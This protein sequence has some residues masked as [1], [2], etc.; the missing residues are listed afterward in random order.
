MPRISWTSSAVISSSSRRKNASAI[1]TGS[2][3][4]HRPKTS[5]NSLC[6][7]PGSDHRARSQARRIQCPLR[8]KFNS[9]TP[10]IR[11]GV[12]QRPALER[13]H[14]ADPRSCAGKSRSARFVRSSARRTCPR[15]EGLPER[16]PV[17]R[18]PPGQATEA[19]RA[20][21][22][23]QHV[24]VPVYPGF[25]LGNLNVTHRPPLFDRPRT[26]PL[27]NGKSLGGPHS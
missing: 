14:E 15:R 10:F 7:R 16:S 4:K 18:P 5:Q 27:M 8:S 2:F 6:L 23:I 17:R 21:I 26:C 24:S 1:P 13:S 25:R 11:D 12:D 19:A 20:R 22:A 9:F 3:D